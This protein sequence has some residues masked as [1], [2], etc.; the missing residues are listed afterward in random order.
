[1]CQA[2][3]GM[4]AESDYSL[5]GYV[6]VCIIFLILIPD[7]FVDR[8]LYLCRHLYLIIYFLRAEK[9]FCMALYFRK[10][11]VEGPIH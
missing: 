4:L 3:P 2:S 7:C 8:H 1:M 9:V 6:S 11:L 10:N 5:S